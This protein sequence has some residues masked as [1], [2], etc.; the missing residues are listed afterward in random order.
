MQLYISKALYNLHFY[1]SMHL[2]S[3]STVLIR[4]TSKTLLGNKG[5]PEASL[6]DKNKLLCVSSGRF[7]SSSW[8]S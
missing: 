8:L 6:E 5:S 2:W 4:L 7:I 1:M 3:S